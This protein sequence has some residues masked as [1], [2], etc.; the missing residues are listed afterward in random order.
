MTASDLQLPTRG[1]ILA[2]RGP[3]THDPGGHHRRPG[4]ADRAR[5]HL[6]FRS[7]YYDYAWWSKLD[8]AQCRIVTRLKSNT[9]LAVV[10]ELAVPEGSAILAD[11]IGHVP[12]RQSLPLA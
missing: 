2:S 12:A 6:R 4:D 9:P 10:E 8:A 7:G 1:K 5:R 3:S 11:R